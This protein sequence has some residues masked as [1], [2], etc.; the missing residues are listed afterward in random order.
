MA[1]PYATDEELR[2]V[3]SALHIAVPLEQA[4]PLV[5]ATLT[6][7]AHCWH[8]RVPAH[9][10]GRPVAAPC[11]HPVKASMPDFKRRAAGDFE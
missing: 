3:H 10:W 1:N 5:L 9:L 2:L 6:T 11:P 7:I 4:S 8:G